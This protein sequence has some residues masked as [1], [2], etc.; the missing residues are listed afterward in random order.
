MVQFV[1]FD[2]EKK[3]FTVNDSKKWY[4][5]TLYPPHCYYID[6][7]NCCHI[8]ATKIKQ[9]L[10]YTRSTIYSYFDVSMIMVIIVKKNKYLKKSHKKLN[11]K[12]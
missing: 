1:Q 5:V 2:E 4:I 12:I 7:P 3:Y 9:G 6:S 10:I 8:L 11:K